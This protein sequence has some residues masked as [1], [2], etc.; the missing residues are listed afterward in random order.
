MFERIAMEND[1]LR[2][3]SYK[4]LVVDDDERLLALARL[5]LSRNGVEVE[6]ATTST[7]ALEMFGDLK[8]DLVILDIVM[9]DL[10]G[11]E[12]LR[13]I[14]ESSD[15][16]V[17]LLSGRDSDVDKARGLDLGA[18]DYLTKP[19]SFLEFE[20]RVRALLRRSRPEAPRRFYD[21]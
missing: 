7:D 5:S 18:D 12:V 1:A 4:V 16:A 17:M 6:T 14:R 13:R 15:V 21:E 11:W 8:P 2:Y 9:P 10:S 20:A 19:F 3:G